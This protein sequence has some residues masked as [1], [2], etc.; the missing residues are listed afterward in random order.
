VSHSAKEVYPLV[1]EKTAT[2]NRKRTLN[3]FDAGIIVVILLA[4]CGFLAARSS[5]AGVNNVIQQK[6]AVCID[7]MFTGVKTLDPN[8]FKV[9]DKSAITVRNQPVDPPM[10]IT[11]VLHWPKQVSFLSP[12]GKKAVAMPD[13]ANPT[14]HDFLVT[15]QEDNA[16]RTK[17]G[18]VIRGN[19]IKLGSLVELESDKYRI[20]GVIADIHAPDDSSNASAV[21]ELENQTNS[22]K[23]SK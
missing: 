14:A 9:G 16:E 21:K 8:I 17:D 2:I 3:P 15:V 22:K 1:I 13:P 6:G 4:G 20:Q 10:T 19:K 11:R 5:H 7:V 23:N 12:D 18:W